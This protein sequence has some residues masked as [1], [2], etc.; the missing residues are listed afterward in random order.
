MCMH[1]PSQLKTTSFEKETINW[2][3]ISPCGEVTLKFSIKNISDFWGIGEG[4]FHIII[5]WYD[6]MLC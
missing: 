5:I 6:Y 4:G 3:N 1:I 2:I